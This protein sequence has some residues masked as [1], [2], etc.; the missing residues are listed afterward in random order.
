M[1]IRYATV[2]DAQAIADVHVKAWQK[3]YRGLIPNK[4]LD[5][6]SVTARQRRWQERLQ[7]ESTRI[8]VLVEQDQVQGFLCLG[9]SRDDD[10]YQ[11]DEQEALAEIQ[12][13]FILPCHWGRGYGSQL[14]E[15]GLGELKRQGYRAVT[16]WV[17]EHNQ[18]ARRFY[19]AKG[20][21]QDGQER[22][23]T[24]GDK[25]MCQLRYRLGLTA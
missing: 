24:F 7:Q 6:L 3:A 17:L 22:T 13:M 8:F 11:Q 18:Q 15:A 21:E 19:Q 14:L 23:E 12:F 2:A 9:P 10:V 25:E 5:N 16:L 20:F 4:V 1:L